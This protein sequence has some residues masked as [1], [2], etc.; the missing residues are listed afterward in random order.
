MALFAMAKLG[1]VYSASTNGTGDYA[2]PNIKT[3][4]ANQQL[5]I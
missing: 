4:S 2:P 1:L 3:F 5:L